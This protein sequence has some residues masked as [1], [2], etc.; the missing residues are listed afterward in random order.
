MTTKPGSSLFNQP[1]ANDAMGDD[2]QELIP[3]V[4]ESWAHAAA[5]WC[6]FSN[7][8]WKKGDLEFGVTFRGAGAYVGELYHGS[9][10]YNFNGGYM[11]FYCAGTEGVVHPKIGEYLTERGWTPRT[12]GR[13]EIPSSKFRHPRIYREST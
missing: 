9:E 10:K 3:W 11:E 5:L 13:E 4:R 1:D 12:Y 2:L 7:V 8:E 6:A